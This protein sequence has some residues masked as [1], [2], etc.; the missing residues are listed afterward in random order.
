MDF[1]IY[2]LDLLFRAFVLLIVARF[3]LSIAGVSPYHPVQN[4]LG[5]ITEPVLRPFR[6][7]IPPIG[8][9]DLSPIIPIILFRIF[10]F[11]L[12]SLGRPG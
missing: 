5:Q 10:L 2:F 9:L 12:A 3:L 1:F 6:G 11:M 4:F 8:N 7:I